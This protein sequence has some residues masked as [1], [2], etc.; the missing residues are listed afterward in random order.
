MAPT[1]DA[2]AI[3]I[4]AVVI[5]Q[6]PLPPGEHVFRFQPAVIN[7]LPEILAIAAAASILRR[8]DGVAL[9]EQLPEHVHVIAVEVAVDA[10]MHENH[11][12]QL[13]LRQKLPG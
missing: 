5:L 10:A 8:Q 11:E 7:E 2:D 9:L 3:G 6:H 4:D 12:R 1:H 13:A